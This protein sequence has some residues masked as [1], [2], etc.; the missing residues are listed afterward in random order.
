MTKTKPGTVSCAEIERLALGFESEQRLEDARDAFDAGLRLDPSSQIFAEG[1]ARVAIQLGEEDAADHCAR[2]LAFHEADPELQMQMIETAAAAL[3]I[4]VIPLLETYLARHPYNIVAHELLADLRAQA[5]AGD[6]FIDSYPAA[7]S[8]DPANKPLLM[9]YWN[10]LSQSRHYRQAIESMD[11]HRS[12]FGGDR[13]FTMLEIAIA[14]HSGQIDLAGSLLE[15]LD[16]RPDA[17]L[18]RGLNRLQRGSPDEAAILL[19]SVVSAQPDNLEAWSLLELAWRITGNPRHDWLIG[20][21]RLYGTSELELNAPQLADISAMLRTMHRSSSQP[22]GQSVRGG[23][24]T[25]GQLFLRNEPEITMLTDALAVAIRQFVG[26]LPEADP[27][28]PLL[29]YRNMGMAFGPSWSVR[30][31]GGGHHAAHFHPGGILSSACYICLP[32]AIADNED[33]QGW[34]EIGRPPVELGIDLPPLATFQPRPGR[35]V[36]FPSFLFHGTRPFTGG[37]RLSV[38]FDLVALPKH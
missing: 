24:Q 34:L 9:S 20:Q 1:R 14:A 35:L 6:N 3:G 2:A 18:A 38:A 33:Q 17:Q 7:L 31:R 30:F 5:G 15:K 36:L 16:S 26:E 29:R 27:R 10:I 21:P 32:E 37:E 12:K 25:S 28:H 13:D 8:K 22:I 4:A 23:T 11:A 19:E